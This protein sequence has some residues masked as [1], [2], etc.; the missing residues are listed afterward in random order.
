MTRKLSH[1]EKLALC[2]AAGAIALFLVF[3]LAIF[4]FLQRQDRIARQIQAGTEALSEM[5]SLQSEYE[6][7][8]QRGNRLEARLV[9][10][11]KGFSLFSF[12]EALAGQT[13]V[14]AHIAYMKPSTGRRRDGRFEVSQVEMKLKDIDLGQLVRYL[15]K[16]ESPTNL[17]YVTRLSILKSG[18]KEDRIDAVMQVETIE[19]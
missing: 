8:L 7:L 15:H 17:V 13:G 18:K 11:K 14:K 1:R 6:E 4:P 5:Q 19:G 2:L 10:R 9:S 3:H 12:V 16:V